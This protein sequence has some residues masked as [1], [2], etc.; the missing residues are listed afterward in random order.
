MLD[1]VRK[2]ESILRFERRDGGHGGIIIEEGLVRIPPT[3]SLVVVGDI[4]GDFRSLA[5][6][7]E[8]SHVV[9]GIE[10]GETKILFLGDYGDRGDKSA[11]V[12]TVLL[13]LKV[14]FSS[15]VILLRGNHEGPRD[16]QVSPHDLPYQLRSKFGTHAGSIYEEL[17]RLFDCLYSAAILPRKYLL[18]HGGVPSLASSID[19]I[20]HA[21]LTHPGMSHLEEILWN[22]PA[23][24][25]HGTA[26]SPRGAG[27]L[28]GEDVTRRILK[29]V[30][31]VTVIRGHEPCQEGVLTSHNGM[32][33][34][35]FSRKGP[36][37]GNTQAAYINLN[38]TEPSLSAHELSNSASRF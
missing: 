4:H 27:K 30:N 18:L 38:A 17:L 14:M 13:W 2:A 23:E 7:L 16:L 12:Y 22:D 20:A 5:H 34:T 33:L 11:E 37:Y 36:P 15:S 10:E 26:M 29:L 6:I 19:D 32:I 35:V 9:E 25:I 1:L 8:E 24:N 21:N 28:F 3:H 31:A